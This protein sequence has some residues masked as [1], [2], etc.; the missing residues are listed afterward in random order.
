MGVNVSLVPCTFQQDDKNNYAAG[1]VS[2]IT[3]VLYKLGKQ[4]Q[5]LH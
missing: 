2:L 3:A 5:S 4:L 1:A